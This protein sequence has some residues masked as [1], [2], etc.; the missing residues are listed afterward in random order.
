MGERRKWRK[1]V[2]D[3]GCSFIVT[4]LLIGISKEEMNR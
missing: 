2:Q 4:L 1:D 3:R